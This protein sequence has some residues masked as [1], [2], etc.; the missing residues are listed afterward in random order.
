TYA[1][2]GAQ[3]ALTEVASVAKACARKPVILHT[4]AVSETYKVSPLTDPKLPD[5][6][7]VVKLQITATDGKKKVS[8][9][10]V[11]GYQGRGHTLSGVY[12]FVGKGTTFPDAQ[13]IAFPAAAQSMD[14]LGGPA[15][16]A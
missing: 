12:T 13:R 15:L 1:G 16:P 5:G 6:S 9:T 8:Q 11:A 4:G 7:V 10:G 14:N 2:T 3:Q